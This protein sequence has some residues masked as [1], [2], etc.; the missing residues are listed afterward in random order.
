[1]YFFPID[2]HVGRGSDPDPYFISIDRHDLNRDAA[3]DDKLLADFP[4]ENEHDA[5]LHDGELRAT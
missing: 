2:P 5:N 3:I 1:M 4:S